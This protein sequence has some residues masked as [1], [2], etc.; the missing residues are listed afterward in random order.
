MARA[1]FANIRIRNV[2]A[3]GKE[4]G[5]TR[6]QPDGELV[7]IFEAAHRYRASG[8][9]MLVLGGRDYG[10]GSSR[11]WAAK[12]TSLLGV[13]IVLAESFERI[14]RANLV[15]MGVL[16]LA[17][18]PG[19]GWR[20]LGLVG[21]ETFDFDGIEAAISAGAPVQVRARRPDGKSITFLA[22]AEVKTAA[23][24]RLMVQG[25]IPKSVMTE[26]LHKSRPTQTH[27]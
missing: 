18:Q 14:H 13:Q 23:E 19:E 21:D 1:T 11:D 6:H 12:G 17:F 8:T 4:G 26:L 24:R 5:Y 2:L 10:S 15:G 9:P 16:P 22:G 7:T 20:V 27:P 25:G 3:E